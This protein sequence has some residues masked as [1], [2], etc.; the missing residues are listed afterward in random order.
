MG[1][2]E[3][4]VREVFDPRQKIIPKVRRLNTDIPMKIN[5]LP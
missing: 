2:V 3:R 5:Y 1:P 4:M